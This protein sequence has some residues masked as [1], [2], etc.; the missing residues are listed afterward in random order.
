MNLRDLSYIVAIADNGGMARAAEICSVGQPTL[1]IQVKKLEEYLGVT[2]FER[3]HKT[4]RLTEAGKPIVALA[5]SIVADSQRL[6]DLAKTLGNPFALPFR[7][8]LFPTLAPY[9]L[10][11]VVPGVHRDFPKLTLR[12]IEEK[13]PVL[14]ERLRLGELDAALL[15]L[16]TDD[17]TFLE[18]PLFDDPFLLAC[19]K[20]HPWAARKYITR[21]DL[22]GENL[23]LLDEGHCLRNQAL[24]VCAATQSGENTFRATSLETLR[25]M[26]ASGAGITLM[27]QIAAVPTR[28]LVYIPFKKGEAPLRKIG[29]VARAGHPETEFLYAL[30]KRLA[31]LA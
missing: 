5:R 15:S 10:P 21:D 24:E 23:L 14:I 29:L 27:P 18:I 9:M 26:V 4:L 30:A 17:P 13:S 19:A 7:L 28:N 1:S 22:H 2:I 3:S 6:R 25:H 12:L 8:G 20:E 16:P 11:R 31:K